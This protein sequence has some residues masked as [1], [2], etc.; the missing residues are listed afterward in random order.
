MNVE[1]AR[2]SGS[3]VPRTHLVA[4]VMT[5]RT[6]TR[7]NIP[8]IGMLV[9]P[10]PPKPIHIAVMQEEDWIVGRCSGKHR[11]ADPYVDPVVEVRPE[12]TLQLIAKARITIRP[13][14]EFIVR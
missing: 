10:L 5:R 14:L 13:P 6:T 1:R 11:S 7:R 4:Q 2:R 3:S 8:R 9:L 12:P